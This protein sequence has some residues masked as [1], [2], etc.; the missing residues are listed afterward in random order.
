MSNA[1]YCP[2]INFSDEQYDQVRNTYRKWWAGELNRPIVPIITTDNPS[3]RKSSPYQTLRFSNAW[4]FSVTPQQLIDAQDWQFSTQRWY[5]DAYPFC[6]VT[7]F[8]AGTMAAFLG[9]HPVGKEDTVWFFPERENIPIEE[10]HFE[11]DENNP[12]LRRVLNVYEEGMEKWRGQVV[13]GMI[14]IGGVMDVLASFRGTE[15]LLMDLYD[16]PEE[17]LRCI[18]ELQELWFKYFDKINDILAPEVRGYSM[19]FNLFCEKPGYIIQSDFSYMIS[20]EMF[21]TFVAPELATSSERIY[22]CLYHMDGVGQIPHLEQLLEIDGIKGIQWVPGAGTPQDMNWD[23]LKSRILASG[24]KLISENQK[25]DGSPID[26]ARN[27]GQ[28]FFSDRYFP[29]SDL[30]AIRTYAANCGLDLDI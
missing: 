4:D 17:V 3:V 15:N 20:P 11:M 28:L 24:I 6:P 1:E 8:G 5:G 14:D 26:I 22:Q 2:T 25:P 30:D 19:W 12:Y 9:C 21:K 13:M 29:A 7:P 23:E 10:L 27:P 18:R 16:D